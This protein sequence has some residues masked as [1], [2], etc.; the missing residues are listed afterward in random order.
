M[1]HNLRLIEVEGLDTAGIYHINRSLLDVIT[2]QDTAYWG[3]KNYL[4]LI[5]KPNITDSIVSYIGDSISIA[6]DSIQAHNLR[7]LQVEGL[8]TLGIH[9]VNRGI[10]DLITAQDTV[11][12]NGFKKMGQG[13][14]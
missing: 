8:D 1:S 9:H 5:N 12:W 3:D 2:M 4:N 7:L 11:N 13:L 6:Y 10:L 14:F